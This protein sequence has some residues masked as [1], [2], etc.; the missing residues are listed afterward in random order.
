MS[1]F[2]TNFNHSTP[3]DPNTINRGDRVTTLFDI[4]G[5]A[6]D[7]PH[8]VSI[9]HADP[10]LA[11]MDVSVVFTTVVLG[12]AG[13]IVDVITDVVPHH[14]LTEDGADASLDS[15]LYSVILDFHSHMATDRVVGYLRERAEHFGVDFEHYVGDGRAAEYQDVRLGLRAM[16][17][18]ITAG[19]VR[20]AFDDALFGNIG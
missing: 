14:V 19:T 15:I 11:S 4:T 12:I 16:I 9:V 3:I 20:E 8:K 5:S 7:V 13:T 1:T 2:Q 18:K 6:A 17:A 10:E